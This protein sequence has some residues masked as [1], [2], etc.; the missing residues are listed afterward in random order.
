M[1]IIFFVIKML[2]L[3]QMTPEEKLRSLSD[4]STC[5][6]LISYI[7]VL[8]STLCVLCLV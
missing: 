8:L 4:D 3:F 2:Y 6:L 7:L 1:T 5:A